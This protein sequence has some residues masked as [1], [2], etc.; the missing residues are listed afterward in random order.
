[1]YIVVPVAPV[2]GCMMFR[3]QADATTTPRDSPASLHIQ[4]HATPTQKLQAVQKRQETKFVKHAPSLAISA[5]APFLNR[6]PGLC[7]SSQKLLQAKKTLVLGKHMAASIMS[8]GAPN[9]DAVEPADSK[10]RLLALKSSA[11]RVFCTTGPPKEPEPVDAPP[12][13]R[14]KVLLHTA[15]GVT[16]SWSIDKQPQRALTTGLLY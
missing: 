4:H 12:E 3:V 15:Q 6:S 10:A 7:L 1:M 2:W 16:T 5:S 9:G 13:H 8:E 11:L 14:C